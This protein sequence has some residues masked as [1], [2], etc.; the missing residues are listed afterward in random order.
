MSFDWNNAAEQSIAGILGAVPDVGPL[1]AA[2]VYIFWPSSQEDI[3]AE[4]EQQVEQLI[5]QKID[6]LVY[7][8]V[9]DD[10]SGL[11]NALNDYL[12]AIQT[13]DLNTIP[14]YWITADTAFDEALPHFQSAGY[15]LLLLPL[16]AQFA[17]LNLSLLRDGVLSGASWGWNVSDQ[18]MIAK[19]LTNAVSNFTQYANQTFQTGLKN[20]INSTQP[21]GHNTEPFQTVNNFVRQMTLSVLDFVTMW[22]YFDASTYPNPV[23]IYLSREIYSDPVGTA[24]DSG[25]IVLPTNPTQPIKQITVWGW[26]R[27]DAVQLLYPEGGGPDGV[28][29]TARMGDQDGGSNKP[30]YGGVLDVSSNPVTTAAGLSGDILNAFQFTFQDGSTT[31]QMG[32]NYPG[33]S[34]F[35]FSYTGEILSSIHINGVSN[36]Y[37]SAD[38]AIFGFKYPPNT[39]PSLD[40][41]RALYV[42]SPRGLTL[43]EMASKA[44]GWVFP[45]TAA[46]ERANSEDWN[47]E[48]KAFWSNMHA[49]MK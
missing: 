24:D 13:G 18:Q 47:A 35:S 26:D 19:K 11:Q 1:L 48:R 29:Q 34:P 7:Q 39:P 4:I 6:Q 46:Q 14:I 43:S 9:Q 23:T 41:I 27:I 45:L 16:F 36:S 22:P 37:K 3:W 33:G 12:A 42:G 40:A 21:N 2:L 32:G 38:C 10:L 5:N 49:S 44:I 17:N 15:E 8:Q 30:P 31:P 28:T 20:V 25:Q